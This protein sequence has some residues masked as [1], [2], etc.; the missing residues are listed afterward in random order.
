MPKLPM[1]LLAPVER[2]DKNGNEDERADDHASHIGQKF[3]EGGVREGGVAQICR[4]LR[5]KSVQNCLFSV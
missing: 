2:V 1:V 3:R 4:K 5:A